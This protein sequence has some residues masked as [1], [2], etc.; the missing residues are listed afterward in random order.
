MPKRAIIADFRVIQNDFP[1]KV[2]IAYRSSTS[3][4]QLRIWKRLLNKLF[5]GYFP[6]ITNLTDRKSR[7]EHFVFQFKPNFCWFRKRQSDFFPQNL[8]RKFFNDNFALDYWS[9]EAVETSLGFDSFCSPISTSS[10]GMGYFCLS[11]VRWKVVIFA[12]LLTQNIAVWLRFF[13]V[14]S[15]DEK[16]F[17]AR[18]SKNALWVRIHNIITMKH[19]AMVSEW[20]TS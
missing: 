17:L 10:Q 15:C 1:R 7:K 8:N 11:L 19:N 14:R 3:N 16:W 20:N 5:T 6:C 18:L 4:W 2:L 9:C 12:H 13:F